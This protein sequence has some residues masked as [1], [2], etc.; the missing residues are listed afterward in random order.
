MYST[1]GRPVIFGG[2]GD[3]NGPLTVQSG[4]QINKFFVFFTKIFDVSNKVDHLIRG[5]LYY[6]FNWSGTNMSTATVQW[7]D[8]QHWSADE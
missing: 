3:R 6:N 4:R 7:K 2:L 5:P 8:K 1:M